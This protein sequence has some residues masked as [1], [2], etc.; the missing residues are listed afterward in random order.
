MAQ[1]L[2]Q[3]AQTLKANNKKVQLIYAFNGSGKTRL[4]RDFKEL[5]APK[6]A[7]EEEESK[8]KI[9]YYN[10]FTEDLFY[11]DN[12]LDY[13]TNRKLII[14]PNNYTNWVLVEQGQESNITRHFQRYTNEK[15]TPKFNEQYTIKDKY[16]ND[17][18][19]PAY[20]EVRFSFQ[21]GND[22]NP[23][24][25]K[26]SKGEESSF[27]WSIFY[28]LLAQTIIVLNEA[29]VGKRETDQFND[30]QYVFIDDPVSSLDD[31][32]LIELAINIAELIKSSQ[33]PTLKFIITTHSP[34]FYNVLYSELGV[35]EGNILSKNDDNTFDLIPKKGDSNL[36]F[37]YHLFLKQTIQKAID[38][39]AVKKYHFTLLRN[40]YEK[41][42]S[43]LGYPRWAEL[44]PDDKQT[45]YNRVI[46]FT[47]H[48]LI[49]NETV[50]EPTDPEKAT[51]KF[52]LDHLTTNYNYWKE[53]K[54]KVE[55]PVVTEV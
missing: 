33:S 41:T 20:S 19:I 32:H 45:Y 28:S 7:D 53:E 1:T 48:S 44:L 43:F 38:N 22:E 5:V 24:L 52:L 21:R 14:Q 34:L 6:N 55:E 37:S 49:S 25:V 10:A 30:L 47:S 8:I 18:I 46:Q 26:I 39:S 35:K 31:N 15:L 4:S 36:S 40:L 51:V 9:M 13:D 2:T 27:I 3:I 29:E 50:A 16:D 54:A 11:W 42:A 23:E 17:V 12:D